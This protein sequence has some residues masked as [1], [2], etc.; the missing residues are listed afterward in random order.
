MSRLISEILNAPEPRFNHTLHGW[1]QMSGR[2]GHDVRLISD[3]VQKRKK[4]LRALQLDETDTTPQ[5]LFHA[6]C[7]RAVVTNEALA[8]ELKISDT[9]T[10]EAVIN[11]IIAFIDTLSIKRDIWT[12][13]HTVIKRLLKKQ[14]P[15]KLLKV[16]GLRSIDSVLK[17]TS[18]PELIT[19]SFQLESE[20]WATK[21]RAQYKK[22]KPTDFQSYTSSVFVIDSSRVQKLHAGG[23]TSSRVVVPNYETGT[24]V[25]VPPAS[26]FNMDVLAITMALLQTLYD[27]RA[28]SA[29]FRLISVKPEFGAKLHKAVQYGL[30][31]KIHD[32]EIGW[33]VLQRY[34]TESAE[35]FEAVE[36]PHLQYDDM[37]LISPIEALSEAVP[38][39]RFW[40]DNGHV[41]ML[42]ARKP[43]SMHLMDVITNA[44]NKLPYE[45]S[46]HM[47]LQRQLWEELGLRYI[48]HDDL[49]NLVISKI[50]DEQF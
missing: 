38:E 5:E 2:T 29:Y 31:G 32:L 1:E 41:F 28:Y 50:E 44:S 48:Q 18:A 26:R 49:R 37:I 6:L 47:H 25:V 3:I 30:P 4:V 22:L 34:F 19:L 10:S 13:K 8:T 12:I 39:I 7:H 16:M 40:S 20:E 45:K 21:I 42:D 23:Y 15:K 11:T 27:L 24:I 35:S 43:V 9:D 14:P 33:T 46:V 17:R 36:Q